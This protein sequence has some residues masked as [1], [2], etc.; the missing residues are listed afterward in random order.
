MLH[1]QSLQTPSTLGTQPKNLPNLA[2]PGYVA[3]P[4]TKRPSV[5]SAIDAGFLFKI[6]LPHLM[7][8]TA[9]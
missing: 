9:L 2:L 5:P 1:C 6:S 3:T 8:T 7:F 4:H